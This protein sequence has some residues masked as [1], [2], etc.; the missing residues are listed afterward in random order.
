MR[1][2]RGV[3]IRGPVVRVGCG[4]YR[5][6]GE[7]RLCECAARSV[8]SVRSTAHDVEIVVG[9]HGRGGWRGEEWLGDYA[10]WRR[11]RRVLSPCLARH[12]ALLFGR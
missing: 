1:H 11:C 5:G 7:K 10:S 2:A 3:G 9:V 4:E 12:Y 6:R 8:A